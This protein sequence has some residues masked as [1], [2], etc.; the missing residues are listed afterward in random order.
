M[1][2]QLSHLKRYSPAHKHY[3]VRGKPNKDDQN[4]GIP[5]LECIQISPAKLRRWGPSLIQNHPFVDG[6]Q[7][8]GQ[9]AMEVFFC[10]TKY[11]IEGSV[12]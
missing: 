4:H 5:D 11:E 6:K 2:A 7:R 1:C 3:R 10:A 8:V 12:D 9:V